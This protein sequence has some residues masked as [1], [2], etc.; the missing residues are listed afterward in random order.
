MESR[1][2]AAKPSSMMVP[3]SMIVAVVTDGIVAAISATPPCPRH[4]ATCR[5]MV[6]WAGGP[7]VAARG[8][9]L[10]HLREQALTGGEC[11]QAQHRLPYRRE[12]AAP[13]GLGRQP[14]A[15]PFDDLIHG[16]IPFF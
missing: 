14:L 6:V 15:Y 5:T 16:F 4:M 1:V 12:K 13:R 8:G 10:C 3:S 7:A 11:G 9:S 2:G